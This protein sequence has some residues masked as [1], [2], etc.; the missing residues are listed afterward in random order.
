MD[1]DE[2]NLLLKV[3]TLRQDIPEAGLTPGEQGTIVFI[4]E[5]PELAFEVEFVD[6]QGS[7]I[8]Q[9]ALTRNT[10]DLTD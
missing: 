6:D 4:F 8:A 5:E 7:T 3:V 10:F 9:L 2:S 1:I